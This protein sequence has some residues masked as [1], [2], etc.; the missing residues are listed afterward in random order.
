MNPYVEVEHRAWEPIKVHATS[1]GLKV[2]S[3]GNITK[4][5]SDARVAL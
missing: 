5:E 1:S 2:E 4:K 3:F